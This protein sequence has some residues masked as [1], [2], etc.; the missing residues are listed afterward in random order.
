MHA[1]LRW[2]T[3]SFAISIGLTPEFAAFARAWRPALRRALSPAITVASV[4]RGHF[5]VDG[6]LQDVAGHV[7]YFATGDVRWWPWADR[8]LIRRA[9]HLKDFTGGPNH[10]TTLEDF[11]AAVRLLLGTA[12]DRALPYD[13][14]DLSVG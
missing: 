9:T 4:H 2:R 11:P 5:E 10:E 12:E 3:V 6:F 8:I 13:L 1:L 14:V 7:V